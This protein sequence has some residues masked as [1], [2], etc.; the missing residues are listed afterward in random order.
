M[1]SPTERYNTDQGPSLQVAI[2]KMKRKFYSWEECITLREV[3]S[4]RKLKHPTIIKLKEVIRENNELFFVF[5]YMVRL[6]LHHILRVFAG[7]SSIACMHMEGNAEASLEQDC[8]LYQLIKDRPK[9]LSEA[10]I[11]S[12]IYQIFQGLAYMH[13]H[14]YF[15]RDIKPGTGSSTS[16]PPLFALLVASLMAHTCCRRVCNTELMQG[17]VIESS[18]ENESFLHQ[19]H[20]RVHCKQSIPATVSQHYSRSSSGACI[21]RCPPYRS[22]VLTLQN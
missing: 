17:D 3:K 5:E 14:G 10:R 2:K 7:A 21:G 18:P 12:I 13:K 15:H 19:L 9:P 6:C 22:G 11:R 4:L 8:N 1:A 16:T 20:L